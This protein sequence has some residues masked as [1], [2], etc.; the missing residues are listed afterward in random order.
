MSFDSTP[1]ANGETIVVASGGVRLLIEGL[2]TEGLPARVRAA[3]RR[4]TSRPTAPWSGAARAADS[5]TAAACKAQDAPLEIYMEGNIEFRQGDR[6]I[7]ADRMFYD[8]RRQIGVIL[9]AELLTPLP[10]IDGYQYPGL[11]RL[12]ADAIRQLDDT[13]FAATNALVTTSRLEEPA[14][15]FSAPSEITFTDVQQPVVDPLTGVPLPTPTASWPSAPAARR[16]RS[17]F[18]YLRGMP[19]FYWPTIA[20]DLQGAVVHHRPRPR[21]QR[22]HLRHAGDGRLRRLPTVRHPQHA[23]RGPTGT[24]APT[25][26]ASAASASAPTSS[27]TAPSSSASSAPPTGILD[28]WAINDDGL[29]NLGLGRQRHRPRGRLPLPPVRPASPA[30][31]ER[32][33]GHRRGRLAQR[34]HV[35]RTVLRSTNGTS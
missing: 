28:F 35:P 29:D 19:V 15:D 16:G 14:Y 2:P 21:R 23:R 5:A 1:P 13:H 22:Q 25:T 18:I 24:S 26:S 34:P 17:N 33:G 11:V 6:V 4:S 10:P 7:Y 32:L 30:A 20:T 12:K 3:G 27:T 31:R 8:V 9:N